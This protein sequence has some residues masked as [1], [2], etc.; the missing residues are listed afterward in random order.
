MK[1]FS[2]GDDLFLASLLD[3]FDADELSANP[4]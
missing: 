4:T 3:V 2:Q 1:I